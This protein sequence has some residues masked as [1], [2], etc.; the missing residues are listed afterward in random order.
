[1]IRGFLFLA[2]L[3][4]F[5]TPLHVRAAD[6]TEHVITITSGASI[7][8]SF[9][10]FADT[11]PG[12]IGSIASGD[13]GEDGINEILV[14]AGAGMQPTVAVFRQ[15]GSFVGSFLA[16]D[17][18]FT[19]GVNVAV[20]DVDGDGINEILTGAKFGGG[21][22][23]RVFDAMGNP[24]YGFFAYASD[25]RGGVNVAC[26]D[27][28]HDGN[29][30]IVTG[31]GL[32]GGPHI[33]AFTADGYLLAEVFYGSASENTGAYVD[34]DDDVVLAAPM[35]GATYT[36]GI[37]TWT[38]G[39]LKHTSTTADIT[40]ETLFTTAV[41]E[42]DMIATADI[43][44]DLFHDTSPRYIV[45][46]ISDQRLTAYSYG[47]EVN[48]FLIS[49]GTY[50]YPTPLGKTTVTAKL[51]TH[52]Y[53]GI[54]YWLPDVAWNLRFRPH[55]YI[56]SAY[57]HNNFGHRMSHGCIN[58][59]LEDAEWIYHWADVGTAVEIVP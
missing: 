19:R 49:S 10:P 54:G 22:H 37:F 48:S 58:T 32:S 12:T 36:V 52:D 44:T 31:A 20:C 14:G 50:A 40:R 29:D 7:V 39:V 47:V 25:F 17:A 56:H 16:Y 46:D 9:A 55:Y 5:I 8:T 18:A 3:I 21:P 15:D 41:L 24:L 1:M 23:V 42:D 28:D 26:G 57:W 34:I 59:R 13:L 27:I 43:T 53:G 30:D 51:P 35:G 38:E 11:A 6:T 2:L 4:S 33:K 45:V